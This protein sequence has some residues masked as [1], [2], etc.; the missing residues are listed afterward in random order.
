M[1]R[2]MGERLSAKRLDAANHRYRHNYLKLLE[3]WTLQLS[4]R[5]R[6]WRRSE[7]FDVGSVLLDSKD[8]FIYIFSGCDRNSF[9]KITPLIDSL[10]SSFR[11]VPVPN[12]APHLYLFSIPRN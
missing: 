4:H 12:T 6:S 11:F 2:S 5:P 1:L 7:P 3:T 10:A 8:P 9:I